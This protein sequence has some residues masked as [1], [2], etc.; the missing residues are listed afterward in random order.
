MNALALSP[1]ATYALAGIV[2]LL[3]VLM[4]LLRPRA[5]RR[6]VS[7]TVLWEAVL[8]QRRK[9][10]T[11]WRW[12]LS[13][14]LCL[15]VGLALAFALGRPEGFG[16]AQPRVVVLLDNSPS[17]A[18]L[19]RDGESR[20]LHAVALAQEVI[21]AAGVD[22]M[23]VDTMGRAPV[24]GFVPPAQAL[25]A[26]THFEVASFGT[27]SVPLL[28][29]SGAFEVH[30]I[31]DGVAGFRMPPDAIVHSVFEP[32][33]NVAVTGLQTRPL[34]ADPLRVEA[35]VQVYNASPVPAR[36]RL[37]LRG[38]GGFE[39]TQQLVMNAGELIDTTFDISDFDKGVIAAAAMTGHDAFARDDIAFAMV[40]P[41][42]A[43]NV[44]L[45]TTGNA[46]LE[47]AIRSLPGLRLKVISPADWRDAMKADAYVFDRFSPQQFPPHGT[48]L[49]HPET[50]TWMQFE[51]R[52]VE[53]PLVSSWA[54]DSS[55][56]DGVAWESLRVGAVSVMVDLP[57]QVRALVSTRDGALICASTGARRWIVAGFS[58]E[59]SNLSTQ[60]GLPVFLG[61]ALR[62]LTEAERVMV[63]GL[64]AVRVPLPAAHVVNG[65]GY[66]LASQTFGGE[67]IFDAARPDIYT[68]IADDAKVRVVAGVLD[69]READINR[70]R[71]D[72]S[73]GGASSLPAHARI[74][75]WMALVAIALVFILVEWMA[76]TRRVAL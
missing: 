61:N 35:F 41:H 44:L 31:S 49:F 70:T 50:V 16:P 15:V 20:W 10:H 19:T 28:P 5:L 18:T 67:T 45:V 34:P 75:P 25:A 56:L 54:R 3:I 62:W 11:R 24:S 4:H 69:P 66:A 13:L 48:L 17:M 23:L 32:A 27:A 26:L 57:E 8:R 21:E 74:E 73:G 59:D 42:R 37:S 65:S 60:P 40:E 72:A 64:G 68:V 7:S 36:V 39:L 46:R 63:S 38:G 6:A 43:R 22:V 53:Q 47:D 76:W 33:I 30:V 12:L 14:L 55:L 51:R 9:Y 71:F 1:F 29:E 52:V 2:A 58:P